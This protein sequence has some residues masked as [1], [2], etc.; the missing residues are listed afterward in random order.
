MRRINIEKKVG[1]I[2]RK[3]AK[4]ESKALESKD[5]GLA[6]YWKEVSEKAQIAL[7]SQYNVPFDIEISIEWKKSRTWGAIPKG[8][9]WSDV[10]YT[11]SRSV[12]GCG[13]DKLSACVAELLNQSNRLRARMIQKGRKN[14]GYGAGSGSAMLIPYFEG[15]VGVSCF[16]TIIEQLGGKWTHKSTDGSDWISIEFK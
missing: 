1:V 14:L 2:M 10:A 13:Y 16:R 11:E 6:K 8:K 7:D 12:T 9:M 15:G 4:N 5:K 3:C